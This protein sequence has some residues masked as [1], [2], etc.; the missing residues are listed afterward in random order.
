M[1]H[2]GSLQTHF[3]DRSGNLTGAIIISLGHEYAGY[4]TADEGLSA[5]L[6]KAGDQSGDKVWRMPLADEY[7]KLINCDIADMKNVGGRAAGSITAAQFLKRFSNDVP[8]VHID[9]AGMVWSDKE[10]DL[11]EKGATGF[12]VRLLDRYVRDHKG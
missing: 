8:W 12:G 9:V 6:Y 2:S 1:V 10:H 7:D 5:A 11:Y 4:F 3:H